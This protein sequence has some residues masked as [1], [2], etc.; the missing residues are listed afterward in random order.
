M[1]TLYGTGLTKNAPLVLSTSA[2]AVSGTSDGSTQQYLL[3]AGEL[4][5]GGCDSGGGRGSGQGT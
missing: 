3:E 5:G 2:T 1:L 4:G